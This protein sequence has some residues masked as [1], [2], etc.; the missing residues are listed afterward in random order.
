MAVKLG[1]QLYS[2]RNT[3][4]NNYKKAL[5][6]IAKSGYRYIELANHNAYKDYGC[7][8]GLS[9]KMLKVILNEL[10]LE[11]ISAHIAPLDKDNIENVIKY[12][13]EIKNENIVN[14]IEFFP[15]KSSV[16]RKCEL[17]NKFGKICKESGIS[18]LYHNHFHEFQKF[19][20]KHILDLIVENTD[21]EYVNFEI[22]VYWVIRGGVD[23]VNY[24]KKLGNRVKLLHLKD[25]PDNPSMMINLFKTIN[26]NSPI[27]MEDFSELISPKDFTEIGEGI[28]NI[29]EIIYYANELNNI[30][31]IILEQDHSRLSEI[32]SIALSIKNFAGYK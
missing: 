26:P 5:K 9:S 3:L 19:D 28:I 30:E 15:D 17:Y 6:E 32:E 13:C 18:F 25:I 10:S 2:V 22:D 7:G 29:Q 20:D 8:F 14:P 16:L 31:Y 12:Q 1:L 4:K 27:K 11:V 23:P 24:L 21:P